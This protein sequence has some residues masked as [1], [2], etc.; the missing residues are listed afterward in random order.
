MYVGKTTSS[1]LAT[2]GQETHSDSSVVYG[3]HGW[4]HLGT[5]LCTFISNQQEVMAPPAWDMFATTL[6]CANDLQITLLLPRVLWR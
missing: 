2:S 3:L 6:K 4:L 5:C 1:Q